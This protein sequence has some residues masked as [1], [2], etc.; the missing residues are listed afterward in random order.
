MF[1]L[2]QACLFSGRD[3]LTAAKRLQAT[4]ILDEGTRALVEAL[5]ALGEQDDAPATSQ[6]ALLPAAMSLGALLGGAD[7]TLR[8]R[9]ASLGGAWSQLPAEE[10]SQ[11]LAGDPRRWLAT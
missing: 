8:Q 10:L 7:E 9:L 6:R 4:R 11:H 5:F 2:A 1:A 3:E